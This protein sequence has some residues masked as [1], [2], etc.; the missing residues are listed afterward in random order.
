MI[1][2]PSKERI[3]EAS[4]K[5]FGFAT[6][7]EWAIEQVEPIITELEMENIKLKDLLSTINKIYRFG[8]VHQYQIDN[9][10]SI[11]PSELI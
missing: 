5:R 3:K 4:Q 2:V 9:I 1:K 10:L 11:N 8:K 7:A 6:G